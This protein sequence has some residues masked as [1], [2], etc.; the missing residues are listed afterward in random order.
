MISPLIRTGASVLLLSGII[1]SAG[2]T[3]PGVIGTLRAQAHALFATGCTG[4]GIATVEHLHDSLQV[5]S[6]GGK[7][8]NA[9]TKMSLSARAEVRT[10]KRDRAALTLCDGG[11]LYLNQN[12]DVMLQEAHADRLKGGELDAALPTGS[13]HLVQTADLQASPAVG[14]RTNL[15]VKTNR[16]QAAVT[17]IEG[18]THVSTKHGAV[19]VD[20]GSQTIVPANRSPQ[21]P[22][23]VDTGAVTKW[24][25]GFS[26]SVLSRP[27]QLHDP[28]HL[29]VDAQGNVYVADT[30]NVRIVKISPSGQQLAAWGSKGDGMGQFHEPTG[31]AV[32]A[33]GNIYVTDDSDLALDRGQIIKLSP[34]GQELA[35]YQAYQA[36]DPDLEFPVSITLDGQGN[37]YVADPYL[38]RA[39]IYKFSPNGDLL[40]HWGFVSPVGVAVDS[41]GNIY[42]A[43]Q[44]IGHSVF[45]IIELGPD[46]APLAHWGGA[47]G[48][49]PG[50]FNTESDVA[51]DRQ[52]N[53][54]VADELNNRV[55][56]LAPSGRVLAV[57]GGA[58]AAGPGQFDRPSGVAVDAQ[59]NVYVVD[60]GNNRVQKYTRGG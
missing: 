2:A 57:W 9:R 18:S 8:L 10:R 49:K 23:A 21:Q 56:E 3:G 38:Y 53:I 15:D 20:A 13:K 12:S 33:N 25:N 16:K 28:R 59:G 50:E 52:G 37:M 48:T 31:V 27:G 36:Q 45:Q 30:G 29:A 39:A 5:R 11:H 17:T 14:S 46:G 58:S 55:Q 26:W 6:R 1:A 42:A 32:D 7:W 34:S 24:A 51:V 43:D 40:G 54:Y 44:D 41:A 4:K 60:G 35:R 47:A 19:T 22:V